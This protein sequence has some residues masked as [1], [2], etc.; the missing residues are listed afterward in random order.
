MT[1]LKAAAD[2]FDAD[3]YSYYGRGMI[4]LLSPAKTLDFERALPPLEA[5][6]PHF[7][8]EARGLAGAAA[9]LS[10]KRL[11]ELMHISP[12]SGASAAH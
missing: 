7:A 3:G 2:R 4:V 9:E 1:A 11:A 8:E 10:P 5:T 12:V 6:W